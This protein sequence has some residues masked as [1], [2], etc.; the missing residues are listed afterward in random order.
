VGT[1]AVCSSELTI[2]TFFVVVIGVVAR[3]GYIGCGCPVD[4]TIFNR[5]WNGQRM[6]FLKYKNC[7][8]FV[9]KIAPLRTNS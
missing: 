1:V 6:E 8:L 7:R 5:K 3:S 9:Q 2:Q 4:N